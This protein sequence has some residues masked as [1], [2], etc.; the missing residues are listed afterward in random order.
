MTI[1]FTDWKKYISRLSQ[2][3]KK[4]GDLMQEYVDQH[5]LDDREALIQYAHAL[6][7]KY[8]EGTAELAC[9]MYDA[10]AELENANVP[11]AE[12]ADVLS[13]GETAKA[14]NGCLKQSPT[15][16]KINST[17]QRMVKQASADTTLKNA[18]RDGAQYAWIPFSDT[19]S[20]CLTLASRGWQYI[21]KKALKKGHADHIHGNCDC[22]YAIRFSEKTK[23]A[24][25]DP[26]KYED[27]YY[28]HS[29][30]PDE[31]INAMRREAYAKNKERI[32]AKQREAYARRKGNEEAE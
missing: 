21:S 7:T 5:G 30:T 4:A 23:V 10:I 1:S 31:K 17:M 15:G 28:S 29:G 3:S 11:I 12:P 20:F 27:M 22:Q 19:C 18:M 8:G 24:G 25:Y 14:I 16:Q 32:L 2:L 9:Q 13:I 6:V 26:K